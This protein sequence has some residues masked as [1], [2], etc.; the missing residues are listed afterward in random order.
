[1]ANLQALE[2]L[3]IDL[4]AELFRDATK[5]LKDRVL[6]DLYQIAT[7][8]RLALR[9]A[10]KAAAP[11]SPDREAIEQ[12]WVRFLRV[13]IK[14]KDTW[15]QDPTPGRHARLQEGRLRE[16]WKHQLII[17]GYAEQETA[18]ISNTGGTT[19]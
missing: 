12:A 5:H 13:A 6:T 16:L 4:N 17:E 9:R 2:L 3:A 14:L 19:P 11:G 1:M 15:L 18:G 8:A 7:E 10:R